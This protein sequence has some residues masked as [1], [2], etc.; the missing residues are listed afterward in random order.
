MPELSFEFNKKY[1]VTHRCPGQRFDRQSVMVYLQSE[2]FASRPVEYVFSARPVFGTQ[3]MPA[4]WISAAQEV[5]MDTECYMNRRKPAAA[6][7]AFS[8]E[9]HGES[10]EEIGR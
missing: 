7:P 5:S 9:P 6:L 1:L 10:Y 8:S 2:K 3:T 4:S